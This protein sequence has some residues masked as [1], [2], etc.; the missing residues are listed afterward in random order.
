MV[1]TLGTLHAAEEYPLGP[2]SQRQAGVPQG[3][4]T[5]Y[6][7]TSK[8][9]PGTLR[10]YWVYVPAQYTPDKPACFMVF[11]DGESFLKEDGRARIPIVFDNLIAK[12][13]MPV[14]IAILINPGVL[15]ALSPGQK[16][17]SNRSFEYDALATGTLDSCLTKSYRKSRSTTSFRLIRMIARFPA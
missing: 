5:H 17:R 10:D 8:V 13:E 7:W 15:K 12:H 16:D 11:Q 1:I 3:T 14:T 4:V 6:T 9:F 2:D